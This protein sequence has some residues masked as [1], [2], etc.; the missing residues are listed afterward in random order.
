MQADLSA[1]RLKCVKLNHE[2]AVLSSES[3]NVKRSFAAVKPFDQKNTTKS[4]LHVSDRIHLD[5]LRPASAVAGEIVAKLLRENDVI[6]SSSIAT[7]ICDSLS[8]DLFSQEVL[9]PPNLDQCLCT[10]RAQLQE[11]SY[12]ERSIALVFECHLHAQSY[13]KRS[14]HEYWLAGT[15]LAVCTICSHRNDSDIAL[16]DLAVSVCLDLAI[17]A[18]HC[19]HRSIIIIRTIA[20]VA[21]FLRMPTLLL[22]CFSVAFNASP[23]LNVVPSLLFHAACIWLVPFSK[24]SSSSHLLS[25]FIACIFDTST[26]AAL[27]ESEAAHAVAFLH[28]ACCSHS[29]IPNVA[30]V[31]P[32]CVAGLSGTDVHESYVACKFAVSV[33]DTSSIWSSIADP[34]LSLLHHQFSSQLLSDHITPDHVIQLRQSFNADHAHESFSHSLLSSSN[35]ACSIVLLGHAVS[36]IVEQSELCVN[37]SLARIFPAVKF[38]FSICCRG[39]SPCLNLKGSSPSSL[40][41]SEAASYSL[42]ELMAVAC[43]VSHHKNQP[44]DYH[45]IDSIESLWTRLLSSMSLDSSNTNSFTQPLVKRHCLIT[46]ADTN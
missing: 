45:S 29:L 20:A 37:E 38:L 7:V 26:Q 41:P 34:V 16:H 5:M 31:V 33:L 44:S 28:M 4:S 40:S 23:C 21:S 27:S 39:K 6:N 3:G 46:N 30:Q 11:N 13:A 15:L 19:D 24:G 42:C 25:L 2:I 12:D 22:E 8:T 17:Y 1:V 9:P 35:V 18:G 32:C 14:I 43:S 36:A 10:L